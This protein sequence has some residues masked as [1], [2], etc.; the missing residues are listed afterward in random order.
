MPE[1]GTDV[2]GIGLALDALRIREAV[3]VNGYAEG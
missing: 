1:A 3:P 2:V